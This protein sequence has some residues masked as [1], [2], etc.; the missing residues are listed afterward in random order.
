MPISAR[1]QGTIP[2]PDPVF[3]SPRRPKL[4]PAEPRWMVV[5]GEPRLWLRDPLELSAE[6]ALIPAPLVPLLLGLDGTRDAPA[7]AGE[8]TRR[9]GVAL[10]LTAI[11]GFIQALGEA[12]LLESPRQ[13]WALAQAMAAYRAQ[14]FRPPRAGIPRLPGRTG[15]PCRPVDTLRRAWT[16]Q[17]AAPAV[18][19]LP[20]HEPG[21]P[22]QVAVLRPIGRAASLLSPH[23]DYAR[24]GSLYAG[25][26]GAALQAV[27]SAEVVIIF[28]TDHAGTAGR[29]TPTGQR[30][31]TPWGVLPTDGEAVQS[32]AE[33]LGAE[34]AYEE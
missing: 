34:E 20:A 32:L 25:T 10:P 31:A 1:P 23:I 14:P 33:A 2:P 12:L 29:L 28:G 21:T 5:D 9:T 13:P 11:E 24:G 22:P 18:A 16:E 19:S 3:A 7:L 6:S 27:A 4:R 8:F 26:W 30:Y 15:G 17:T